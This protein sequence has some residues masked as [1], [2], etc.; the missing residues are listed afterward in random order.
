[1]WQVD[2][3]L[4]RVGLGEP[5]AAPDVV[6]GGLFAAAK[7][8]RLRAEGAQVYVGDHPADM[9]AAFGVS[10]VRNRLPDGTEY[11][12]PNAPVQIP[13]DLSGVVEGVFGLDTHPVARRR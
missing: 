2:L 11:R 13:N 5:P 10:L 3:H 4:D 7:G 6:V 1:M 12:A 8:V 9:E